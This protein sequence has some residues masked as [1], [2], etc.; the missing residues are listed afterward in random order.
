MRAGTLALDGRAFGA[1]APRPRRLGKLSQQ[2]TCMPLR[3]QIGNVQR[4]ARSRGLPSTFC[5]VSL[6]L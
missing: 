4:Q 5:Q 6:P 2:T 3:A 1:Q